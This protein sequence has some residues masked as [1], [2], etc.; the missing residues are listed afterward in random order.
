M[1][2]STGN[3]IERPYRIVLFG[4]QAEALLPLVQAFDAAFVVVDKNPDIV[5]CY[6]GDGTLLTAELRWPGIP[7]VPILNSR[8]GHRCIPKSPREVVEALA[9][10]EMVH[11]HY[12]KLECAVFS[13]DQRQEADFILTCLNEVNVHMG[14]INSAVRFCLWVNDIPFENG[15]EVVSDG[16]VACTAFGSSAYFKAIT[17]GIFKEGIGLAFKATTHP[18]N[19]VIV[20]ERDEVR[21]E[22]TRGPAVLAFD[23]S[24]DYLDLAAG[25]YLTVR[26][27]PQSAH[28]LTCDPITAL[29]EPF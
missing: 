6:G 3:K 17:K 22:I 19:H 26:K 16:F 10:N 20:S 5:I 13:S 4:V 29:D 1:T 25:D 14:R 7:K 11:S 27:H 28:M 24:H 2:R 23:N 12:S 9:R 21:F 8:R 15:V 18:V